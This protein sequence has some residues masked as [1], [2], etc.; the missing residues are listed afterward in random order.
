[1]N[2]HASAKLGRPVRES[3]E[4][5]TKRRI[6]EKAI[7]LFSQYG[8]DGTSIRQIAKAAG[9]TEGALYRH[10]TGKEAILD[11]ILAYAEECIYTPLPVEKML[12]ENRDVSIFSGLLLPLPEIFKAQPNMIKILRIMYSEMLHNKKINAC[13]QKKYVERADKHMEA[14]FRRCIDIGLIRDCNPRM[15][16]KMFNAIRVQWSEN[17]FIRQD[18]PVNIHKMKKELQD[19]AFFLEQ[20]FVPKQVY[21]NHRSVSPNF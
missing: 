10:Y 1:M 9:L 12:D 11:A 4:I 14:L 13:F 15:L 8:Y 21:K 7:E 3:G 19:M 18:K 6:F 2:K 5:D 16:A 20:I 17:F